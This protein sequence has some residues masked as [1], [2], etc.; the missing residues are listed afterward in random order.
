MSVDGRQMAIVEGIRV[1][2]HEHDEAMKNE[3]DGVCPW[4]F[5]DHGPTYDGSDEDRLPRLDS[6]VRTED[7]LEGELV[8]SDMLN[9]PAGAVPVHEA[10]VCEK[11][12]EPSDASKTTHDAVRD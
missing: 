1:L 8:G 7:T 5:A 12:E 6:R 10:P 9:D 11:L 2:F 4:P 3:E